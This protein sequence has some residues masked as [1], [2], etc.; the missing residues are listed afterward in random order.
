MSLLAWLGKDE[1]ETKALQTKTKEKKKARSPS[2]ISKPTRMVLGVLGTRSI[3]RDEH[4]ESQ[5]MAPIQE[6][7]GDPD[8]I[9][10][11]AE[12]DSSQAIQE[13]AIRREIPVHLCPA[14]WARQGRKAGVLRD[15]LIQRQA[16]HLLFLQGPRST[17]LAAVAAR[18][19]KKGVPVVISE[20]PG[21]PV[22]LPSTGSS[23]KIVCTK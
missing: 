18:L 17:A 8:L 22:T 5:W 15:S 6:A 3:I 19:H 21:E 4:L 2:P 10:L 16:T 23:D 13:W 1:I 11:P 7:W 12:S 20:R 14:D 9:I